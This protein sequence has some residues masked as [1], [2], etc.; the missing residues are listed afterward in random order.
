MHVKWLPDGDGSETNLLSQQQSQSQQL[1]QNQQQLPANQHQPL[2]PNG[3]IFPHMSQMPPTHFASQ[4]LLLVLIPGTTSSRK[5]I[6][7]A[8][9]KI[10]YHE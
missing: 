1:Q 9:K 5:E 2:I 7:R 6:L 8:I 4:V 3:H 10:D